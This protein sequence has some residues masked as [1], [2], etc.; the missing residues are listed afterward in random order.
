MSIGDFTTLVGPG[1][2]DQ[3]PT[4]GTVARGRI[5]VAPA[6]DTDRLVVV[7]PE[8]SMT[9]GYDVPAEHWEH[10][11]NLPAVGAECLA[12]FDDRGDAW[13]PLWEGMVPGGGESGGGNIDGGAPDSVYGGTPIIDGDGVTP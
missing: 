5:A 3:G 4:E 6:S 12:A 9:F 1:P 13:V 7:V 10:A 8:F 11:S 2:P